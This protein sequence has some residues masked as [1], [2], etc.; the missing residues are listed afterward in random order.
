MKLIFY[1]YI[2]LVL[3]ACVTTGVNRSAQFPTH[4]MRPTE[5]LST[6]TTWK[7]SSRNHVVLLTDI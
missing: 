6:M 2:I 3:N 7:G 5:K 4:M 1:I